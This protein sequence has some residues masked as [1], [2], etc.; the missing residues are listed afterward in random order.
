MR[1]ALANGFSSALE[2][3]I[4]I[5]TLAGEICAAF[6]DTIRDKLTGQDLPDHQS[7]SLRAAVSTPSLDNNQPSEFARSPRKRAA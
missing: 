1:K 4:G 5:A 3:M 7:K 6:T 2:N